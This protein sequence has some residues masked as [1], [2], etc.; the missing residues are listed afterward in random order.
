[1]ENFLDSAMGIFIPVYES[2]I[3]LAGQYSK[4]CGRNSVTSM[5]VQY[6][7]R[8][9][10]RNV[11][12]KQIGTLFPELEDE[13]SDEEEQEEEEDEDEFSR[14]EGPDEFMNKMNECYDTWDSWEPENPAEK[15][16][17]KSIDKADAKE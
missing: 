6:G 3:I 17:K 13:E 12:G 9:A 10:A 4:A 2:A 14:Y 1:M 16:I 7:F 8:Y 5:D 11:T 15:S